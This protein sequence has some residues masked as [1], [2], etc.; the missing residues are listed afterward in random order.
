MTDLAAL[1]A[2]LYVST[3]HWTVSGEQAFPLKSDEVEPESSMILLFWTAKFCTA[4]P[5]GEP[6]MSAI[7]STPSTSN[8]RPAIWEP[9]SGLPEWSADITST[10]R[11]APKSSAAISAAIT[12]PLPFAFAVG[13]AI[14]VRT[15]IFTLPSLNLAWP[16][17]FG[18][19]PVP[20]TCEGQDTRPW[21]NK[22]SNN[23]LF[24]PAPLVRA[25]RDALP[26]F[27]LGF[28]LSL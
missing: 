28:H 3:V 6:C 8:Q 11:P 12:E 15:P 9:M 4:N 2:R 25:Y 24:L 27:V 7:A 17:Q 13:P 10:L 19:W 23:H 21:T 26:L 22:Y 5:I 18:P 14:S 1:F 16:R 20:P